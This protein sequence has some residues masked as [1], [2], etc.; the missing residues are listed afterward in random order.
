MC[1]LSKFFHLPLKQRHLQVVQVVR[2]KLL[3]IAPST[4]FGN[5]VGNPGRENGFINQI[6]P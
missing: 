3:N 6:W 5:H 4:T 2:E 1:F